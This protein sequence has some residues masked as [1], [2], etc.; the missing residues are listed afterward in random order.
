MMKPWIKVWSLNGKNCLKFDHEGSLYYLMASPCQKDEDEEENN[1]S[2]MQ[3]IQKD[4]TV[5]INDAHM[6]LR[7]ISKMLLEKSAKL[8]GWT[9]TGMLT[10][11]NACAKAKAKAK[12]NDQEGLQT[13]LQARRVALF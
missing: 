6:L 13:R 2:A 10:T 12:G 11:C 1:V 5:D 7:H 9:L 8:I 3:V 4:S